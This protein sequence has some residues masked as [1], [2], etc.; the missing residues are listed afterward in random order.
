MGQ[1][2]GTRREL[3]D[4][5]AMKEEMGKTWGREDNTEGKEENRDK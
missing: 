2:A 3:Q 4:T 5:G 1:W